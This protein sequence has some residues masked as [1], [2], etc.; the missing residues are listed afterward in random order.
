MARTLK[1]KRTGA[2]AP[3]DTKNML[4]KAS[5]MN[6][7]L[8][9]ETVIRPDRPRRAKGPEIDPNKYENLIYDK[10]GITNH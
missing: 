2:L 9:S 3:L 7:V 1:K 5:A 8:H 10:G 4:F 6:S